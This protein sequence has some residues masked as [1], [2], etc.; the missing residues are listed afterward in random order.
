MAGKILNGINM[1]KRYRKTAVSQYFLSG[2]ILSTIIGFGFLV[3]YLMNQIEFVDNFALP[4]SAGRI[5]LFEAKS[6]YDFSVH[7]LANETVGNSNYLANLPSQSNF[8]QSVL[9]LLF[10]LPFSL[11]PYEISRVLW[12]ITLSVVSGLSVYFAV[13]LSAWRINVVEQVIIIILGVLWL[14]GFFSLISGQ[15]I[16]LILFFILMGVFLIKNEQDTTAGLILSLTFGYFALTGLV[17]IL[18]MIWA[19]SKR[20]WS[21]IFGYISGI[22]FLIIVSFL[23]LPNWHLDWINVLMSVYENMTVIRTP[24]TQFA[25]LIPGLSNFLMIFLHTL[26]GLFVFIEWITIPHKTEKKYFWKLSL[27]FI[28][29]YLFYIQGDIVHLA[30]LLPAIFIIFEFLTGRYGMVG[31]IFSWLIF[32]FLSGGLW[33]ILL[34]KVTFIE[35]LNLPLLILGMPFITLIG[36]LWSKWWVYRSPKLES[37]NY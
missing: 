9:N 22:A 7:E 24:L 32:L 6:P 11:L 18:L 23:L 29:A 27:V 4:W 13:K 15:L 26:V 1:N 35:P 5:W 14:P 3:S 36:M 20:R 12:V 31:R 2:L 17:I 16:P 28:F 19:I 37:E 10:Y 25:E 34:P 30:F 33:L 8:Q 21:L